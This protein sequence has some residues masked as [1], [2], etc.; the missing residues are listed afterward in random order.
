MLFKDS[1][2]KKLTAL[3]QCHSI[4]SKRTLFKASKQ[5]NKE[6]LDYEEII[7]YP[8]AV[9]RATRNMTGIKQGQVC[10]VEYFSLTDD[11]VSVY[12]AP[13]IES[14]CEEVI[15]NGAFL[16][17][18][19]ILIRKTPGFVIYWTGKSLRRNQFP[20]ANYVALTIHKLMGDT[21][22]LLATA[23]CSITSSENSLW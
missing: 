5:L 22:T 8:N 23:I 18:K 11:S 17:W 7:F 20:L 16:K 9:F 19:R 6:C 1:S 15:E 14:L 12:V 4:D 10:V 3:C 21:F 13:T 2:I